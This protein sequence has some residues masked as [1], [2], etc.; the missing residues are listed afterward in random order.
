MC[1]VS[2]IRTIVLYKPRTQ[3][4]SETWFSRLQTTHSLSHEFLGKILLKFTVLAKIVSVRVEK[5]VCKQAA[6]RLSVTE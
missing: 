4:Q 2:H 6:E 3:V 5:P 1:F